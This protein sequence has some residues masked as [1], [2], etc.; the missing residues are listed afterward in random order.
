MAISAVDQASACSIVVPTDWGQSH[1]RKMAK[2]AVDNSTA[3]IDGEVVQPFIEGKQNA[4]V[5][6]ARVLKG[7]RATL[8]EIGERD[9]CSLRLD[10][11]G[12]R[13]RMLLVG[14]PKVYDLWNDGSNARYEDHHLKSDRR[15]VWPYVAGREHS[16]TDPR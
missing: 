4:I 11:T 1:F 8:F 9:S 13:R 14:G 3:I 2:D 6:A 15:K 5:R 12:E 16:T 10:R 7:P